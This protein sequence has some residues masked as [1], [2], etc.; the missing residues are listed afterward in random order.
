[1]LRKVIVFANSIK[2]KGH[3]V[4]G[5]LLASRQWVRLVADSSGR[6]LAAEKVKI[7]TTRGDCEVM[8]QFALE[9]AAQL[10]MKL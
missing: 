10:P 4:T 8:L 6:E 2:H 3:C 5:K 9:L 1:M 7:K